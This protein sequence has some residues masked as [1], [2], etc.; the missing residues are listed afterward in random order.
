M[1]KTTKHI[2]NYQRLDFTNE[3]WLGQTKTTIAG[4]DLRPPPTDRR[5]CDIA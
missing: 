2:F 4:M 1:H 3:L 5:W